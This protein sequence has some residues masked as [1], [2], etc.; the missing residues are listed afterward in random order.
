MVAMNFCFAN[1]ESDDD[2]LMILAMKEKIFQ[3]VGATVVPDKSVSEF[4]GPRSLV[5][6]TL[7][8]SGGHDQ[9]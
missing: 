4:A 7:E 6:W 3:P 5:I 2:V 1:T 9:V 8:P